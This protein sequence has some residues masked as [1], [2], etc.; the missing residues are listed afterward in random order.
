M[1]SILVNLHLSDYYMPKARSRSELTPI[2]YKPTSN[3][4]AAGAQAGGVS[5]D[6]AWRVYRAMLDVARIDLPRTVLGT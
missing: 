5:P 4:L 2:I 3:M 6:V 1:D